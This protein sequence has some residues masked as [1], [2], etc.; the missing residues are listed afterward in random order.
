[1]GQ[2]VALIDGHVVG[3]AVPGVKDDA[4][5]GW[6]REE[7]G[8]ELGPFPI[9]DG[10][11]GAGVLLTGRAAG[12]VEGEDGL[13]GDVHGGDI[14]AAPYL[15]HLLPVG[16]GVEGCLGEQGRVLLGGH[17]QLVVEGMVPDLKAG[18]ELGGWSHLLHVIPVGDDTVLDGVLERE[19]A[20]LALRLIA[21]I[22]V[23]LPHAHHDTLTP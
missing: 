4:W 3:D 18:K 11:Q 17:A 8:L 19:D 20:P 21:Y 5:E 15:G 16:L 9:M 13:D 10:P 22:A 12:G 2:R 7:R 1:V 14:E 6:E 23:F